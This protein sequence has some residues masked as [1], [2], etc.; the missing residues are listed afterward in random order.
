MAPQVMQDEVARCRAL[1][2]EVRLT[3]QVFDEACLDFVE[4]SDA[5][6]NL[7]LPVRME[8]GKLVCATTWETMESAADLLAMTCE[9]PVK[10]LL[11]EARPI[12]QYIAELYDYEGLF[13]DDAA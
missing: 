11:C 1:G 4:A 12:E 13:L 5:W 8:Q 7:V 3:D 9:L 6:N 2:Q 10:L